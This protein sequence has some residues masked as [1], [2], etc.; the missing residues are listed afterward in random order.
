MT[1][2]CRLVVIFALSIVSLTNTNARSQA[3]NFYRNFWLPSYQGLRLNYC[4][5]DGKSCGLVVATRYCQMMGYLRADQQLIE[6]NVGLT[7]VISSQSTCKGWH[8]NGFKTIRCVANLSHKPP[9]SYHYR[10]RKFVYP[11]FELYR[12]AW[13]YDDK[14]GCGRRAAFSFCRRMGFLQTRSYAIEK[15]VAA[16]KAIANQKLCFG[17]QCNAFKFIT[18]SR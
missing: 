13:C 9:E 1:F 7:K 3:N 4:G 6:Y 17:R 8:C 16:T 15:S 12:L 5:P 10:Y 18:C 11:R 2:F 14:R